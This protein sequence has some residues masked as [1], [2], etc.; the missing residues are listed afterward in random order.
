MRLEDLR[1]PCLVLDRV[2]LERNLRRMSSATQRLGVSL[3][4]HMKTAKSADVA[5]IAVAGEAGGITVSTL[6][7][8]EYFAERGCRDITI[9]ARTTAE[10]LDL[11][12]GFISNDL[13]LNVITNDVAVAR[14]IA[15]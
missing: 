5:L 12:K 8:P 7:E 4:P 2:I 11:I 9:A 13:I 1:T 15:G 6:A 10:K 14:A 3:R